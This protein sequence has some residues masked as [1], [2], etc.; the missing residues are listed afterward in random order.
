[1]SNLIDIIGSVMNSGVVD[2]MSQQTGGDKSQV[3]SAIETALPL[4]IS[5]LAKNSSN[6]QG[7]NSLFNAIQNDHSGNDLGNII[8]MVANPNQSDGSG[9]LGHVFGNNLGRVENTVSKSSGLD[10]GKVAQILITL[11]PI[12]MSVLG[13]KQQDDN[14]DASGIAGLLNNTMQQ[15]PQKEQ[16]LMSQLLDS[17]NDGSV[18]DDVAKIGA[19]LL[20]NFLK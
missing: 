4:L 12:V 15:A 17:D 2:Q 9:I 11:A 14:M 8:N 1:M 6:Q 13:K 10:I 20:G 18:V 5:G 3:S 19:N 7:A 16:S